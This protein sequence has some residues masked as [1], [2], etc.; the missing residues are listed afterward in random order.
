M[1]AKKKP[2]NPLLGKFPDGIPQDDVRKIPGVESYEGGV[3]R[4]VDGD[5]GVQARRWLAEWTESRKVK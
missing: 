2:V 3:I 1:A 4:Y 5:A